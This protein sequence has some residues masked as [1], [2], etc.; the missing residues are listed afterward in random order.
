MEKLGYL[1]SEAPVLVFVVWFATRLFQFRRRRKN[2]PTFAETDRRLLFAS[3]KV[4]PNPV[5]FYLKLALAAF[6]ATA[7]SVVEFVIL[8]PLGA[9]LITG[10]LILTSATIVHKVLSFDD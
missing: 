1:L 7:A 6:A 4:R 9:T 8:A 5:M 3:P 10:A 2:Q